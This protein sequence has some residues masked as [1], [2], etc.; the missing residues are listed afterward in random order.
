[1]DQDQ[2][3][4]LT[5]KEILEFTK[6]EQELTKD[7]MNRVQG[8]EEATRFLHSELGIQMRKFI[9]NGKDKAM[10]EATTGPENTINQARNEFQVWSKLESI[11]GEIIV[12]GRQAES[13]LQS[14][15]QSE[16]TYENNNE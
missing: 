15:L 4:V 14:I 5:D 7:L 10:K 12:N 2:S 6:R 16:V 9:A 11:F 8:K 1:M 3:D 13:Q